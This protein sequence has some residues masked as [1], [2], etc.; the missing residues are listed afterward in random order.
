MRPATQ[1]TASVEND[2]ERFFSREWK[3]KVMEGQ[4]NGRAREWKGK[5]MEGQGN[6]RGMGFLLAPGEEL[7]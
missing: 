3:G 5:G 1:T 2:L 7:Q 6:G 4:G